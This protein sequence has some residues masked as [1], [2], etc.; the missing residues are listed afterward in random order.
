MKK[1]TVMAAL[2]IMSVG[3]AMAAE[4]PCERKYD[5]C[6]VV[7]KPPMMQLA[8]EGP[9]ERKYDNCGVVKKPPMIQ[10]AAEGRRVRINHPFNEMLMT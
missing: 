4:G 8:A 9:C 5:N 10:L 6:G 7:K 1:F 2:A 3:S